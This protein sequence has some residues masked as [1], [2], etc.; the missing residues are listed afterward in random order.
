MKQIDLPDNSIDVV[1]FKS[2]LGA[3]GN[4][5][6]QEKALSEIYRVLKKNGTL[7]FAENLKAS[8]FHQFLRDKFVKWGKRWR[9]ITKSEMQVWGKQYTSQQTMCTGVFALFGRNERQRNALAVLDTVITP[10]TPKKWRYIIFGVF[11]K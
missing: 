5:A 3:L 7:L 8:S 11:K 10:I 9:Y 6:D 2:V 4:S 1:V